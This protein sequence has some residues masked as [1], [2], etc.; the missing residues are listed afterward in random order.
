MIKMTKRQS[1]N[2]LESG[3]N[4]DIVIARMLNLVCFKFPRL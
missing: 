1:S 3:L 2:T 4:N